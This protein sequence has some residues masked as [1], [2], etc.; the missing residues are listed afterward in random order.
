MKKPDNATFPPIITAAIL[1]APIQSTHVR[2]VIIAEQL[3]KT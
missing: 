2:I 1:P 3:F